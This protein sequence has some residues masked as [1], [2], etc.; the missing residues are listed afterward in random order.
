[1]RVFVVECVTKDAMPYL[2][3]HLFVHILY[4][5]TEHEERRVIARRC[6]QL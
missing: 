3:G 1:M 4:V 2:V 5:P 6:P